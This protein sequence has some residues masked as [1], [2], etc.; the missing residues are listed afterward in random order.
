MDGQT[1]G[2]ADGCGGLWRSEK[3]HGGQGQNQVL[4]SKW[5]GHRQEGGG[6]GGGAAS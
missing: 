5:D 6:P 1:A 4:E 3:A 2:Q